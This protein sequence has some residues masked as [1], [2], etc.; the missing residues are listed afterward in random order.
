MNGQIRVIALDYGGY[1]VALAVSP[2]PSPGSAL[3]GEPGT[4]LL[5]Q[6]WQAPDD[7]PPGRL[8]SAQGLT[9]PAASAQVPQ[10]GNDQ[11][12]TAGQPTAGCPV[13]GAPAD[14]LPTPPPQADAS[15][16]RRILETER[17]AR[18]IAWMA[19]NCARPDVRVAEI[20]EIAG[21]SPRHLQAVF[22]RDFGRSPLGLLRDIGLH[23]VHLALTGRRVPAPASI[24]AAA[25]QAGYT[26][27]TR[28]KAA[29]RRRYG[30]A[31]SLRAQAPV[32]RGPGQR[33]PA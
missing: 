11:A 5:L 8:A 15:R 6:R 24:A 20:A 9:A 26:R 23:R 25:E 4:V 18:V 19:A 7:G 10:E 3:A 30:R 31:P 29:Y 21:I 17:A 22:R 32:R 28:F 12:G 16:E 13:C 1:A 2:L 14:F 33:T 27:V